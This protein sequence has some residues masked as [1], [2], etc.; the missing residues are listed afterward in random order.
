MMNYN[1]SYKSLGKP[2]TKTIRVMQNTEFT[3]SSDS[4]I[5]TPEKLGANIEQMDHDLPT[6]Y[7]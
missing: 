6:I 3:K 5:T 1:T 2:L 4:T 7:S